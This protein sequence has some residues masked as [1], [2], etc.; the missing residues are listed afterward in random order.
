MRQAKIES[1][2]L[3]Y[4]SLKLV[5]E[6]DD[7]SNKLVWEGWVQPIRSIENLSAI[8][9]DLENDRA[10]SISGDGEIMHDSRCSIEHSEHRLLSRFISPTRLYKVRVEDFGDNRLPI[11]RV[12]EPQITEELRRHTWG[13]DEICGFAPW[14]YPWDPIKSSIVEFIDHM[15]I[16]LVKWNVF[17]QTSEWIGSETRH[18]KEFLIKTIRPNQTCYCGGGKMYEVCHRI[19]DGISLFGKVWILLEK[20][21]VKHKSNI[22]RFQINFPKIK[23]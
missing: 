19:I 20:W 14:K 5:S 7:D 23:S 8:L 13:V 18:D 9:D 2:E 16:W 22:N 4:P 6:P 17:A 12:L 3:K 10:V 21:L 1:V 15:M 11:T